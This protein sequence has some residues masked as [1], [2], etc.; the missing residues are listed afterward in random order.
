MAIPSAEITVPLDESCARMLRAVDE[1]A[2]AGHLDAA[3]DAARSLLA[4]DGSPLL[5]AVVRLRLASLSFID[6][7]VGEVT[8]LAD[9]VLDVDGLPGELHTAA[10]TGRLLASIAQDDVPQAR[11]GL[12]ILLAH[13]SGPGSDA[14]EAT[15]L[16]ALGFLA[17][18]DGRIADALSLFRTAVERAAQLRPEA[19]GHQHPRLALASLLVGLGDFAGAAAEIDAIRAETCARGEEV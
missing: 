13:H 2:A 8:T 6:G 16:A 7:R 9:A 12:E 10:H 19:R 15:A 14:A 4:G 11:R 3:A 17:W 18:D 1:P 5:M